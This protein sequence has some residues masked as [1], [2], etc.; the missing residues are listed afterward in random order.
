M[1][2]DG[3]GSGGTISVGNNINV[4]GILAAASNIYVGGLA[5]FNTGNTVAFGSLN[6]GSATA[7]ISSS[8]NF[9]AASGYLE[10]FTGLKL[11]GSTSTTITTLN[12]TTTSVVINGPVTNQKTS[13][14]ADTLT[15][16]GT[17][18]GNAIN[19]VIANGAGTST[20][21]LI[22]TNFSVWTLAGSKIRQE[23]R[24]SAAARW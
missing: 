2:N 21:A 6:F 8:A 19:G 7:A 14:G 22:K 16:N 5:G 23:P 9:T 18:S 15:L 13:S 11:P 1:L 24:R 4:T 3:L 17:S 10:S 20:T 12:P